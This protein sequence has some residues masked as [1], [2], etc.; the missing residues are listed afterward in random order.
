MVT[1]PF[2]PHSRPDEKAHDHPTGGIERRKA[3]IPIESPV[4]DRYDAFAL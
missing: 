2:V 3:A 1:M 4:L